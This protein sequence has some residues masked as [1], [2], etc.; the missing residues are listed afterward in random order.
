MAF[1][2]SSNSITFKG[3]NLKRWRRYLEDESLI[4][5]ILVSN[6]FNSQTHKFYRETPV[7]KLNEYIFALTEII[8]FQV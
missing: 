8:I 7:L 2:N 1:R 6:T 3:R 4:H 5:R